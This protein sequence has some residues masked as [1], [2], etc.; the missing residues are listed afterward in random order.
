MADKK[1]RTVF[2]SGLNYKST[3]E[4]VKSLFAKFG[5]IVFVNFPLYQDSGRSLGYCHIEFKEKEQ[6]VA[7]L[8]LNKSS[9]QDR[10]LD[11]TMSKGEK[12]RSRTIEESKSLISDE[13]TTAFVKNLPYDATAD[14]IAKFF[15]P[16]GKI[17]NVRMARNWQNGNFKGFCYVDF[18]ISNSLHSALKM[19][20]KEFKGRKIQVDVETGHARKGFRVF[21]EKASKVE[22]S[23][24]EVEIK[25]AKKIAKKEKFGKE[26]IQNLSRKAPQPDLHTQKIKNLN[27]YN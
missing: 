1:D 3:Q 22:A 12:P 6:A 11:V 25:K 20:G 14:E 19:D 2:V 23:A 24:K 9:F 17:V 21:T 10:Y 15:M 5:E 13:T 8:E 7:A 27:I 16:C 26:T 4:D 18:A